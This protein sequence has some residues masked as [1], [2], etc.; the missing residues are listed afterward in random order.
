MGF[1]YGFS[2]G[3]GPPFSPGH[4]AHR[5]S[6]RAEPQGL[7][8]VDVGP[9]V[10]RHVQD[11]LLLDLPDRLIQLLILGA[12]VGGLERTR[13]SCIGFLKGGMEMEGNITCGGDVYLCMYIY[14][15]LYSYA[16]LYYFIFVVISYIHIYS[17]I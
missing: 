16:Y 10:R 6:D 14:L 1:S 5:C 11:D 7:G 4:F 15:T 9:P 12:A 8:L 3:L 2:Y 13:K 17:Y